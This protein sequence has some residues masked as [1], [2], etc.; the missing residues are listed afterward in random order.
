MNTFKLWKTFDLLFFYSYFVGAGINALTSISDGSSPY[1]FYRKTEKTRSVRK[2]M[3]EKVFI[4]AQSRRFLFVDKKF[5]VVFSPLCTLTW[6]VDNYVSH[7]GKSIKRRNENTTDAIVIANTLII[8]SS[9]LFVS[10][11]CLIADK[12]ISPITNVY[13]SESL[14]IT[15][16]VKMATLRNE[17]KLAALD[18]E[19]CR[20]HLRSN[21]AQNSNVSGSQENYIPQVS[22]E[23]ESRTRKSCPRSSV[24]RRVAF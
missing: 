24:E 12:L 16:L 2:Q 22:Q 8:F 11:K 10:N 18:K 20:K 23:I 6:L 13:Q 3:E 7:Q 5:Q 4:S 14:F 15:F 21:L 9:F 17:R 19:N 1:I